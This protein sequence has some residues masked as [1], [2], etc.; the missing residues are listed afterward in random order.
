MRIYHLALKDLKQLFKSWQTAFFLLLM[1]IAFTL[2]FGFIFGG[3]G[4]DAEDPRLLIGV[5]DLD[6]SEHSQALIQMLEESETLRP[7]INADYTAETY[8]KQVEIGDLHAALVLPAGFGEA[9]TAGEPL[10]LT[11]V[12]DQKAMVANQAV[13]ADLATIYS[14]LFGIVLSASLSQETFQQI[15]ALSPEEQDAYYQQA[16]ELASSLWESPPVTV[17]SSYTGAESEAQAD[18]LEQNAFIHSSPGMMAQFAIAGLIGSAEILVAERKSRALS[19]MLTT[20][21]PRMGILVGHFLA[22]SAVIVLQLLVLAVFGQLFLDLPYFDRPTATLLLIVV[23]AMVNGALGLLIGALAKSSD[24]AVVFALVP[25]FVFSGLGGAWTPLE[26][27][28]KSVQF[29]AHFTPV[30]WMMDGFKDILARGAGLETVWLPVVVLLG[31][32]ALFFS[33]GAWRFKFE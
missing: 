14:R 6:K 1:P 22:M 28:S 17:L 23:S 2:L 19:R 11:V 32:T 20:G 15:A 30:A 18:A 27:T 16:L 29:V 7:I 8:R 21:F 4:G 12:A 5:M 13:R 25:M 3:I 24:T 9:L 26:Y 31:F 33:L 10:P